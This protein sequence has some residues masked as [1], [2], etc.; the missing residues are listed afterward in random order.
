MTEP[1]ADLPPIPPRAV[2]EPFPALVKWCHLLRDL[3]L[4][5]AWFIQSNDDCCVTHNLL[6]GLLL[7]APK[8]VSFSVSILR[9][10]GAWVRKIAACAET[11]LADFLT[12]AFIGIG[13]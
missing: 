6:F 1:A 12:L 5:V 13:L 10:I 3:F 7:T 9:A 11:R 2:L 4:D 8:L